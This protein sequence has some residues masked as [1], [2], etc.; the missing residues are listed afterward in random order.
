MAIAEKIQK[1]LQEL[2]EPLQEEA[3]D[4]VEYLFIK[5]KN[6]SAKQEAKDWSDF[7]LASAMSG[8]EDEDTPLYTIDD[9][10]VIFK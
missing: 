4:F 5:A 10:K 8:M 3:L 9:L 2:P 7:S 6:R 1:Y